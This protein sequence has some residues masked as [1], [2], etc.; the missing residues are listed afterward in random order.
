MTFGELRAAVLD[1]CYA[2]MDKIDALA[3]DD[4]SRC[5]AHLTHAFFIVHDEAKDIHELPESYDNEDGPWVADAGAAVRN[6]R[7]SLDRVETPPQMVAWAYN[8]KQ[9]RRAT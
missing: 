5:N 9:I 2:A 7:E 4:V 6:L 1:L 8:I 3:K